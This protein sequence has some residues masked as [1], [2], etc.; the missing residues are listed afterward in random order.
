VRTAR[1]ADCP[2]LTF[3][4]R[5]GRGAGSRPLQ[6]LSGA[7]NAPSGQAF[8]T[9][10]TNLS[11]LATVARSE[12]LRRGGGVTKPRGSYPQGGTRR[13]AEPLPPYPPDP[14]EL[15]YPVI[16]TDQLPLA[17]HSIE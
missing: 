6:A 15:P 8:R 16:T 10:S 5:G 4:I 13:G 17:F 9:L 11:D 2:L 12:L 3:A 14:A 1:R 7:H